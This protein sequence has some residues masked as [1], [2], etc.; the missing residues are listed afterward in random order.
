MANNAP[1]RD[2]HRQGAVRER[3]QVHNPHN[4]RWVRQSERIRSGYTTSILV[5][6][7][8]KYDKSKKTIRFLFD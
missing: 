1:Y 7:D 2:N 5:Y 3:S 6:R 8:K 4:D